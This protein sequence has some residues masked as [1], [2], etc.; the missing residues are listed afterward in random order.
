MTVGAADQPHANLEKTISDEVLRYRIREG[1]QRANTPALWRT[2]LAAP[3]T[4][5]LLAG[6][7]GV[8]LTHYYDTQRL[9]TE[10]ELIRNRATSERLLTQHEAEIDHAFTT[11]EDVSRLLD[12]R[13]WRA[14]SLV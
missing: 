13:L 11:F 12:R 10:N 8:W 2:V 9:R 3:L 14:R 1:I 7:L 4:S 5:V 6:I